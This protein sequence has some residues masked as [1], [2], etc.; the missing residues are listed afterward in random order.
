V[1]ARALAATGRDATEARAAAR[2][3]LL[4]RAGR[5]S[6]AALRASFLERVPENAETIRG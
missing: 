4:A 1:H 2:D 6:D 3:R 5:I